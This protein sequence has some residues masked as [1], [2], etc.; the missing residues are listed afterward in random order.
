MI[1]SRCLTPNVC[2][3]CVFAGEMALIAAEWNLLLTLRG[4]TEMVCL[5]VGEDWLVEGALGLALALACC[6]GGLW[7][8]DFGEG[9]LCFVSCPC[10]IYCV[11]A[12]S[13]WCMRVF[14]MGL[15]SVLE[16]ACLCLFGCV[17]LWIWLRAWFCVWSI[18]LWWRCG[19]CR[20]VRLS[21]WKKV[22]ATGL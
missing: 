22:D 18:P 20:C 7:K 14:D 19:R 21:A 8:G 4:D 15:G 16:L 12:W 2:L 3:G 6:V 1:Q 13:Y 17:P 9:C 5:S 11:K 10:F